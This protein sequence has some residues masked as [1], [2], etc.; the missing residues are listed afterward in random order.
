MSRPGRPLAASTSVALAW[1]VLLCAP[2]AIFLGACSSN[3][4][5]LPSTARGWAEGPVRWLLLPDEERRLRRMESNLGML[6]FIEEFWQR[7]DPEP[8]DPG[9]S[10]AQRFF[11]R[12]Q[13]ADLLYTGEGVP[14]SLTDRGR[15]LVL[16]G[17]PRMMRTA[18]RTTP[19]WNPVDART[20]RTGTRRVQVEVWGFQFE[21]LDPAL[22]EA[23]RDDDGELPAEPLEVVF[24][25]DSGRTRLVEGEDLLRLAARSAVVEPED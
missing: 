9:N 23:L 22:V 10:F 15:A 20:R 13:S 8:G 3:G 12:V 1:V 24:V 6:Q 2:L 5:R 25:E 16:L 11:E 17:P 21:D 19:S 18:R 7:R 14:G 4:E